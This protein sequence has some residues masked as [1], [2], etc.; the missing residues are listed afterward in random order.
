[1]CCKGGSEVGKKLKS[2]IFTRSRLVRSLHLAQACEVGVESVST[3]RE[4]V[5]MGVVGCGTI[6]VG[7]GTRKNSESPI[8]QTFVLV[9][10]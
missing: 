9:V 4:A 2:K 7:F 5:Q 8:E 1:M 3:A 6:V 10:Y